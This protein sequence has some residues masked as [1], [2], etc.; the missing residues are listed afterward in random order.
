MVSDILAFS[1][2]LLRL[3]AL[4]ILLLI[5][6]LCGNIFIKYSYF[7]GGIFCEYI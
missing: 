3:Y 4:P 6:L 7:I 2:N 1:F 5:F